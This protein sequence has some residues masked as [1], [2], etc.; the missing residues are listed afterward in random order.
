MKI[1]SREA[2][3]HTSGILLLITRK[4]NSDHRKPKSNLLEKQNKL[5]KQST[6]SWYDSLNWSFLGIIS[7][8]GKDLLIPLSILT[9]WVHGTN[10]FW[11]PTLDAYSDSLSKGWLLV[12]ILFFQSAW[13]SMNIL[14]DSWI[15]HLNKKTTIL[16]IK[17]MSYYQMKRMKQMEKNI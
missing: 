2:K 6:A 15:K 13:S 10:F 14:N 16:S 5:M 11:C 9:Q 1:R 4:T 12:L 8:F 17:L 3:P 7:E